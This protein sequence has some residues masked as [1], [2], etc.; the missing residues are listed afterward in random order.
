MRLQPPQTHFE[1][2]PR[3]CSACPFV[4]PVPRNRLAGPVGF[5]YSPS[6]SSFCAATQR[7]FGSRQLSLAVSP[8]CAGL[9]W[10]EGFMTLMTRG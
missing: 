2:N 5:V 6:Q 4:A 8:P 10:G 3:K 7:V 1:T 9:A